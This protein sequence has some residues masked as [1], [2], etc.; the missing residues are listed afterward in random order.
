MLAKLVLIVDFLLV[1]VQM[2]KLLR[3]SGH[4]QNM[5]EVKPGWS[6]IPQDVVDISPYA[7]TNFQ[8]IELLCF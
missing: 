2:F 3:P 1:L 6:S 7:N 5:N 4:L 8:T